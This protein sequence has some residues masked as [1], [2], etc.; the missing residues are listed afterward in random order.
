M[1]K[2]TVFFFAD[3]RLVQRRKCVRLNARLAVFVCWPHVSV[4]LTQQTSER[5]RCKMEAHVS[6]Y[7]ADC[8]QGA[9]TN[10]LETPTRPRNRKKLIS[11]TSRS[12]VAYR[13]KSCKLILL[14]ISPFEVI[15]RVSGQKAP[16]RVAQNATSTDNEKQQRKSAQVNRIIQA[17]VKH[18]PQTCRFLLVCSNNL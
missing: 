7:T 17:F 4:I 16:G 8:M 2:K 5:L 9:A 13:S 6:Y 18:K 12:V 15:Q 3:S 14:L 11:L 10:A 1:L